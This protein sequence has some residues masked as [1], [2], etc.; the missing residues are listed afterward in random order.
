MN[1]SLSFPDPFYVV[2]NVYKDKHKGDLAL[3]FC[4]EALRVSELAYD[5]NN[6]AIGFIR[7][8]LGVS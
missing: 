7:G 6:P 1:L 5:C 2:Q 4:K 3:Q 8:Q